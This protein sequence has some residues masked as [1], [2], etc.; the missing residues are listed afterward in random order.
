[1]KKASEIAGIGLLEDL[2]EFDELETV[3]DSTEFQKLRLIAN[4]LGLSV[5]A[6]VTYAQSKPCNRL[7]ITTSLKHILY[8]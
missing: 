6:S 5:V 1:L 8:L 7:F 2:K 3:R 4:V